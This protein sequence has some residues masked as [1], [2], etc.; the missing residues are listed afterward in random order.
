MC[1]YAFP[2]KKP[3]D[4]FFLRLSSLQKQ[5]SLKGLLG[6][7]KQLPV[8]RA[9]E[10]LLLGPGLL[11]GLEGNAGSQELPKAHSS[12]GVSPQRSQCPKP[13][14]TLFALRPQARRPA[15]LSLSKQPMGSV[16]VPHPPKC[17]MVTIRRFVCLVFFQVLQNTLS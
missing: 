7:C 4:L 6:G 11:A 15:G 1:S 17:E 16:S 14:F 8:L 13:G 12:S 3:C 5:L 9:C 2:Y 10:C